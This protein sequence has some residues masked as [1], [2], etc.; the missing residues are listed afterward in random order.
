MRSYI[1]QFTKYVMMCVLLAVPFICVGCYEDEPMPPTQPSAYPIQF[2]LYVNALPE[3]ALYKVIHTE[4]SIRKYYCEE[5][6]RASLYYHY[7]GLSG[8]FDDSAK[9]EQVVEAC[10]K[11]EERMKTYRTDEHGFIYTFVISQGEEEPYTKEY[12]YE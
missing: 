7:D 6:D 3:T 11:A 10:K 2:T 12:R 9:V 8:T 1:T 4:D 5:F